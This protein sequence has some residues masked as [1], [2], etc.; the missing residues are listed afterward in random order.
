MGRARAATLASMVIM[1]LAPA[2]PANAAFFTQPAGSPYA[3]GDVPNQIV[4]GD[5][6]LDT[7]PDLAVANDQSSNVTILLG[8]GAGAFVPAPGS[9]VTVGSHPKSVAVGDYNNDGRP[10]FAT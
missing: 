1:V 7:K 9:P 5:F 6:N 8:D 10:D 3:A 4:T 2:A